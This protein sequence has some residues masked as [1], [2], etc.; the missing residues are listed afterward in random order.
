M[1]HSRA[2]SFPHLV[3]GRGAMGERGK[4]I[5]DV[6]PAGSRD[7]GGNPALRAHGALVEH[8]DVI[9]IRHLVDQMRRPGTL[10]PSDATSVRTC[11]TMSARASMSSPTV[12]S[13]SSSSFG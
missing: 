3:A 8:N 5:P 9:A 10:I 1:Y 13:S 12:G 6:M 11:R 2:S 4:G 7:Y